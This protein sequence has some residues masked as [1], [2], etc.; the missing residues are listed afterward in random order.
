MTR[1]MARRLRLWL[2][3]KRD[4]YDY[5]MNKGQIKVIIRS[6]LGVSR[7]VLSSICQVKEDK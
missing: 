3:R 6:V 4:L 2:Q 7:R 1:G 5:A